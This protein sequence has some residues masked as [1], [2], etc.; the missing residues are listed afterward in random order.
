MDMP[1][2]REHLNAEQARKVSIAN[3][4]NPAADDVNREFIDIMTVINFAIKNSDLKTRLIVNKRLFE[5]IREKLESEGYK[6]KQSFI[7]KLLFSDNRNVHCTV[8][9]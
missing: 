4:V 3:R 6:V 1:T 5:K 7:D 9:W 2:Q 8:T